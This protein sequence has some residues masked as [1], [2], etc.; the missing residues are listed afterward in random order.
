[1]PPYYLENMDTVNERLAR[2]ETLIDETRGVIKAGMLFIGI[3]HV[4][5]VPS[6]LWLFSST[7]ANRETNISQDVKVQHLEE[8]CR[9]PPQNRGE[10]PQQNER[11]SSVM[12]K[13]EPL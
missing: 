6:I 2:I 7:I 1:V 3:L 10:D 9:V 12:R 5:A 8:L 11:P 13:E 4:F